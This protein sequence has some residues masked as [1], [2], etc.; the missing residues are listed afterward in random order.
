MKRFLLIAIVISIPLMVYANDALAI[1]PFG[2]ANEY[3]QMMIA[4]NLTN[5]VENWMVKLGVFKIVERNRIKELIKEQKL[6]L[7]GFVDPKT[8]VNIGNLVGAKYVAF[9]AVTNVE[10]NDDG[11]VSRVSATM[12]VVNT[13]SGVIIYSDDSQMSGAN[14]SNILDNLAMDLS[15]KI[16]AGIT[17]K[18]VILPMDL[19]WRRYGNMLW[20]GLITSVLTIPGVMNDVWTTLAYAEGYDPY[21]GTI[22]QYVLFAA[23]VIST[24]YSISKIYITPDVYQPSK[25]NRLFGLKNIYIPL[26]NAKF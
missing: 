4:Q 3:T 5:A 20:G 14:S 16:C 11:T 17:G 12:K 1:L 23:G 2:Y 21:I 13:S 9:G 18:R 6:S 10:Y 25:L 7:A 22:T 15:F 26:I 8:A 24:G 19:R